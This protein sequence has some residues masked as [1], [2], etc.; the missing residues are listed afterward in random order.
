MPSGLALLVV[1][2][3]RGWGLEV[4]SC[5][6]SVLRLSLMIRSSMDAN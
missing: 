6:G 3:L 5:V 2:H 1:R 4:G